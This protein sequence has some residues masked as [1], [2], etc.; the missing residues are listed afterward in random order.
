M[1]VKIKHINNSPEFA[2]TL[3]RWNKL[4][5]TRQMPWKGEKDPYKVWLSEIILQQTRV[6]QGLAYY[7]SF[8]KQFSNINKLAAASDDKVFKLWEGLGYYSRCRNLLA[9]ARYISKEKKGVFPAT[10]EEIVQ[11]KGVGPYT[12]AAIASFVYNLPHAVVDGNVFRVLSR[13]FGINTPIDT[14]AGKKY[15]TQLANELLP[16][17]QAGMYNQALMDF[18]AVVCKPAAPLCE[19]CPFNTSCMALKNKIVNQLPVKEKKL[20]QKNR[21][22]YFMVIHQGSKTYIQQR[23]G[24]DIWK[25]LYQ[26]PL[27]E[28]PEAQPVPAILQQAQAQDIIPANAVLIHASKAV[29]QQLTHQKVQGVFVQVKVPP[30]F[31]PPGCIAV[32]PGQLQQYAF[33]KLIHL[34]WQQEKSLSGSLEE[35]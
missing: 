5:N 32:S 16:P 7:N 21:F 25:D 12:A 8:I 15:F 29:K 23:T 4:D 33:P 11:L 9:T 24:K 19:T 3:L 27:V 22:F 14:T 28:T 1:I 17:K 31:T 30:G 35:V 18:G 10:Y 2:K 26:Y 13:V 34:L 20:L 6:E